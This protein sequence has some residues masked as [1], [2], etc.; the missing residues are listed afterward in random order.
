MLP[1]GSLLLAPKIAYQI[2]YLATRYGRMQKPIDKYSVAVPYEGTASRAV[3]LYGL[4]TATP[5]ST[6]YVRRRT[7][8]AI[9]RAFIVQA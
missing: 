8:K 5:V 9:P 3:L 4:S 2:I 6:V 7:R 1:E